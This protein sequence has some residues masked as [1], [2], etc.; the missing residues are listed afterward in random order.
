VVDRSVGP[1]AA[2]AQAPTLSAPASEEPQP[3]AEAAS[4][5]AS[6]VRRASLRRAGRWLRCE[7]VLRRSVEAER[8]RARLFRKGRLVARAS[9]ELSD[10]RAVLRLE[11][12]HRLA[13][14]T[15]TL[16]V[17]AVHADGSA[18]SERRCVRVAA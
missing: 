14:G 7:V 15:Y 13:A 17:T 1:A 8:V 6:I 4:A 9:R 12:A 18:T 3:E 5:A 10:G 11:A 16:V 2:R